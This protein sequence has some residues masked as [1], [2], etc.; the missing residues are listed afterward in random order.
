MT[1]IFAVVD[2]QSNKLLE[3]SVA[4]QI[5]YVDIFRYKSVFQDK[6]ASQLIQCPSE[7]ENPFEITCPVEKGPLRSDLFLKVT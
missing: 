7:N 4:T 1:D 6:T 5:D 3:F 2:S